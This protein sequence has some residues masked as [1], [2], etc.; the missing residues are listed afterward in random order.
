MFGIRV[1]SLSL[2]LGAAA[3]PAL[4]ADNTP[5]E[6][7]PGLWEMTSDSE[8]TGKPPLPAD[9]L[10]RLSPEQRAKVEGAMQQSMGPQH[11][12][13]RHCVTEADLDKGFA[14]F[15]HMGHGR[16]TQSVDAGT[17]TLR[18]GTFTCSGPEHASGS[19][20]FEA[21]SPEAVVGNWDVTMTNGGNTMTV[22]NAIQG[23]W[24]SVNCGSAK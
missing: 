16:C 8:S 20:R 9:A 1:V 4:A 23:K 7:R 3:L 24:L 13:T 18:V 14:D 5:L 17:S 19:Y 15:E 22:R 21:R 6:V 12:V 10:A 11:R 2:C